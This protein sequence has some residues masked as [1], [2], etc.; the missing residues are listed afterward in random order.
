[1]ALRGLLK[2]QAFTC[3]FTT[4]EAVIIEINFYSQMCR[5]I[6]LIYGRA[7]NLL[8]EMKLFFFLLQWNLRF[9]H[10][11][12]RGLESCSSEP[13]FTNLLPTLTKKK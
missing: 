10:L 13:S 8:V 7:R 12:I 11:E 4:S 2:V 5:I 1:M 6:M 3:W 9:S